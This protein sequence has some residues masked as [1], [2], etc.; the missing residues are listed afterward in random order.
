ML[1]SVQKSRKS[2]TESAA[3][4]SFIHGAR[5]KNLSRF[6]SQQYSSIPSALHSCLFPLYNPATL[7]FLIF[8]EIPSQNRFGYTHLHG[9]T[10]GAAHGALDNL[11]EGVENVKATKG[12]FAE[13]RRE[14]MQVSEAIRKSEW[15]LEMNPI[16]LS[17][18]DSTVT[19]HDFSTG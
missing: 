14:N 8:W 6:V 15:N 1:T 7:D 11:I 2:L 9:V 16:V 3:V 10:L 5:W 12:M 4:K 17:V 13:T 19:A 18:K